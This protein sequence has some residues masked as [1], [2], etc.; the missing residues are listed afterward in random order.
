LAQCDAIGGEWTRETDCIFVACEPSFSTI[1]AVSQW[2]LVVLTL[3][4]LIGGK[5]WIA[6]P[7]RRA[8]HASTV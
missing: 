3:L 8:P 2:G 5:L 7:E 4:L 6:R 1:P